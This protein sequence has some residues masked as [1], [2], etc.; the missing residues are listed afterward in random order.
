MLLI[1]VQNAANAFKAA[2]IP[3]LYTPSVINTEQVLGQIK[4]WIVSGRLACLYL[5][6]VILKTK[7]QLISE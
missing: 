1:L 3:K 2:T 4:N 7:G 5:H 6:Q